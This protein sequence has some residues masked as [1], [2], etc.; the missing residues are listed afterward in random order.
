[1]K[2]Y[3]GID[4]GGTNVRVGKIDENNNIVQEITV[5][6]FGC[7][8][9]KE[10]ITE[11]IFSTLDKIDNIKECEG[12]G[13]GVPG[14]VDV[15]SRTMT[16]ANNLVGFENYPIASLIEER[17]N[18]PVYIENDANVAGLAEALLGAGKD[19]EIVY[20]ITHSTGIGGA[21][22]VNGH[23]VSG[24]KGFA[25][26]IGNII[27]KENGVDTNKHLNNGAI[28]TLYSG[29]ALDNKARQLYGP[30]ANTKIL[31]DKA[32]EG[33]LKAISIIDETSYYMGKLLATISQIIDPHVFV[34]GGG[35]SK[36]SDYYWPKMIETYHQLF[37]GT[38]YAEVKKAELREPG[39]LGASLLVR[40]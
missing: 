34:I 27:V 26:E 1:M 12:I 35:V 22:I 2:Y 5:P 39:L 6:S 30:D 37:N 23:I 14:P 24:Q 32:K 17:Y 28:E 15:Y 20:Y 4:L 9:P 13:I 25:G 36:N 7:I 8:G 29:T 40:R 16:I 38:K 11:T 21:L 3:I 31:F 18:I 33:D 19:K 10:K